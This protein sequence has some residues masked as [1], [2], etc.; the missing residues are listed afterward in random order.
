MKYLQKELKFIFLKLDIQRFYHFNIKLLNCH[1]I[2][3]FLK[4]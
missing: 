3:F 1:E 4:N 2:V